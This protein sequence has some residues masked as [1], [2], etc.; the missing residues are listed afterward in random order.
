MNTTSSYL[1]VS[2]GQESK[3]HLA[4]W[5]WLRVSHKAAV[6]VS[7]GTVTITRINWDRG[8]TS[9]FTVQFLAGF[10][11]LQ[12]VGL[13][14]TVHAMGA[15]AQG[16]HHTAAQFPSREITETEPL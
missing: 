15:S 2:V 4:G 3:S 12:A 16:C 7:A 10:S 11:S 9:Q 1:V 13:R 6:K 14:A 8:A 5:V